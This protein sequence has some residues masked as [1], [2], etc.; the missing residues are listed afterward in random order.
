MSTTNSANAALVSATRYWMCVRLYAFHSWS[1]YSSLCSGNRGSAAS[2]PLALVHVCHRLCSLGS[3]PV[4]SK[5]SSGVMPDRVS[6]GIRG[7]SCHQ[8]P[9]R[10]R[11]RMRLMES[12]SAANSSA[13]S[14]N[15]EGGRKGANASS[16]FFSEPGL[17][18]AS[19]PPGNAPGF[20]GGATEMPPPPGP[21]RPPPG[22]DGVGMVGRPTLGLP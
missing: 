12:S 14:R 6:L 17:G 21:P 16:G 10:W 20:P 7:A 11:R 1:K 13:R 8:M 3:T 15:S 9:A 5:M 18:G 4:S 19:Y 22:L 2:E